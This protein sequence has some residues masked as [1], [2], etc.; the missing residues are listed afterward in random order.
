M[1]LTTARRYNPKSDANDE[2]RPR[3]DLMRG[4]RVRGDHRREVDGTPR[5]RPLG[6]P[7]P[8][9]PARALVPRHL[10][11]N[12][13]RTF[14]GARR[15]G[16]RR[17]TQLPGVAAARRV[18]ADRQGPIAAPD[19]RCD[20]R[21]RPRLG[22]LHTLSRAKASLSRGMTVREKCKALFAA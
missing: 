22:A 17:A 13:L 2:P 14:A 16:N 10:A 7:S 15:R 3:D 9:L 21:V 1:G 18:R 4:R 11:P 5:P 20:A 19:H 8:F 6:G 12:A